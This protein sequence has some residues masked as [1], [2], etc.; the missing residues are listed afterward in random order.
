M[1]PRYLSPLRDRFSRISRLALLSAFLAATS[2][3]LAQSHRHSS[4]SPSPSPSPTPAA[5]PAPADVTAEQLG[6]APPAP[7][8]PDPVA[9]V[10]GEPIHPKDLERV[11]A[12]LLTANGRNLDELSDADRKKAFRSTLDDMIT[13]KLVA[14]HSANEAVSDVE[15]EKRYNDLRNQYGANFDAEIKKSGQTPDQIRRNIHTQI[16]QQQW[17][18]RRIAPDIKVTPEEVEKFY[19]ESPPNRFDAPEMVRASHILVAVRRDAPPEDVLAAE[20]KINDLA[21]R[22]KK[23]ESFEALAKQYSDDP[24]AKETSGDLDYF[25]RERIMPEFADA[26]FKLKVGEVSAPVRTQF[27]YHLIKLTD[28]KPAHV[29]T[30]D[31]ARNQI[32]EYLQDEK[33]RVAITNAIQELKDAAKIQ[34][35]ID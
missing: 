8:L 19:K 26:A 7:A 31:E 4:P 20:T 1:H 21:A 23:G 14:R 12:A 9:T 25:S 22:V 28:R 10:D 27:G 6:L 16:A 13:D 30:L 2:S 17:I 18:E 11:T 29:A 3:L 5:T 24:K 34:I 33:R 32:A 15:V 35:F